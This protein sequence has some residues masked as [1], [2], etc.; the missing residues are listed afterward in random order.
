MSDGGGGNSGCNS[1]GKS[2]DNS[3][4]MQSYC[5]YTLL[6]AK[7]NHIIIDRFIPDETAETINALLPVDLI[8]IMFPYIYI[9]CSMYIIN[10]YVYKF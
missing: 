7:P 2:D 4:V 6:F 1:Y 8:I 3:D 9:Y 5:L 10:D